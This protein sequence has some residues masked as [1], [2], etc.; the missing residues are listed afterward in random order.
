MPAL[1]QT[2]STGHSAT[3]WLPTQLP[4]KPSNP[5]TYLFEEVNGHLHAVVAGRLQQQQQHLQGQHL[6]H[7]LL[8]GQV[9]DE[10]DGR[11]AHR[12]VVALVGALELRAGVRNEGGG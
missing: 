9:G 8:V 1:W 10:L 3:T 2:R 5:V 7:H 11:Q 12:L 4:L 6:V